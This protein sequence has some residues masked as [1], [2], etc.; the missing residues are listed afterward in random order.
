MLPMIHTKAEMEALIETAG[1][2]PFTHCGID[3]L[4]I[5]E[6]TP[7]GLWF[8]E[9]VPGPWEWREEILENG[10]FA[11]GKLLNKKAGYVTP[12][13][14]PDL[15]NWRR[16]G[17]DFSERY[18]E[19]LSSRKEKQIMDLLAEHGP[20]LSGELKASVGKKGY[21]TAITSLQMHT[22]ITV[23]RFEHKTDRDG[24]PYGMGTARYA[25]C[26][27]RWDEAFVRSRYGEPPEDSYARLAAQIRLAAP[28][29]T[30]RQIAAL[31]R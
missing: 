21:E 24:K 6:R 16:K 31:L 13:F 18:A 14:F 15:V 19:G 3:G 17:L 2:L 9:D 11:Y 25:T 1:L 26:E 5:E 8:V 20:M 12:A 7:K 4:S 28:E 10:W 27:Q 30:E 23:L 22:Y 29:A